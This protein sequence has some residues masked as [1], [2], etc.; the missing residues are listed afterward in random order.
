[1]NR[2]QYLCGGAHLTARRGN[3]LPHAKLN[4]DLVRE[5]RTNRH[6]LTAKQWADQL[7]LHVRTV[8]K[9]RDRRSWSHVQ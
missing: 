1:M 8:D 6:G 2:A 9:V 5:I 7:G 3:D 4:P